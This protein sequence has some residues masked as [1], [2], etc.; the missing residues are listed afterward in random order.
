MTLKIADE[1][2]NSMVEKLATQRQLSP[3]AAIR[4]AVSNELAMLCYGPKNPPDISAKIVDLRARISRLKQLN[5]HILDDRILD[6]RI[7]GG[8]VKVADH[9]DCRHDLPD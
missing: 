9:G 7:A 5:R 3:V 6:D 4:L 1:E 8:D 2:I